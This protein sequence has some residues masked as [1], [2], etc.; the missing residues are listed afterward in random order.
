MKMSIK[1]KLLIPVS[2]VF[3]LSFAVF[4]WFS[5]T[6]FRRALDANLENKALNSVDIVI[7]QVESGRREVHILSD[8]L[9]RNVLRLA[10]AVREIVNS[11]D[12][13]W[14]EENFIYLAGQIGVGEI[15]ITDSEG[16]LRWG[17]VAGFYGFDFGTS[18]QTIPF[19]KA[20]DDPGFELAQ[21]P[22][23]RGADNVLFQYI[24][25]AGFGDA[26]IVQ[27]GLEPRELEQ[28][29]AETDISGKITGFQADE[30]GGFA[31]GVSSD[32]EILYHRNTELPGTSA[33]EEPWFLE[34]ENIGPR[35]FYRYDSPDGEV[36][37]AWQQLGNEYYAVQL[38]V[39]PYMKA[40]T[41]LLLSLVTVVIVAFIITA[42]LVYIF[43]HRL[44][45]RPL[46]ELETVMTEIS[47]GEGDLTWN[48][49]IESEDEVGRV[50]GG[51]NKFIRT[52][53]KLVLEIKQSSDMTVKAKNT[54][55]ST[56]EETAASVAE[57]AA[58]INGIKGQM[59]NL[60]G[61]ITT[62]STAIE[63]VQTVIVEL[64]SQIDEQTAAVEQSSA[65]INQMV[66]SLRNVAGITQ[67]K[68]DATD[69]LVDTT[70]NGGEQMEETARVVSD[71]HSSIDSISGMVEVIEGI[72]SQTNLL[73]MNAAIE[74]AHAGDAGR[75]FAVVADEIRKLAETSAENSKG[76]GSELQGIVRKIEAAAVASKQTNEAFEEIMKE[77]MD[78]S[79]A[80]DEISGS[81]E[82][83][84]EGG[85]QI[86]GAMERLNSVSG[87][88]QEGAIKMT[89]GIEPM[90]EAMQQVRRISTEVL[91]AMNEISSGTG[92]ISNAMEE[93]TSMTHTLDEA[94]S[95]L[96]SEVNRFK[97]E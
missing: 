2:L 8:A 73:S 55:A 32:G 69:R 86:L 81:T 31:F 91:G 21:E 45:A 95:R 67:T 29:L 97:T 65:S 39:A 62:S 90:I 43:L 28:A 5:S 66:A 60:D 54:I 75:G 89:H 76:I 16:V 38:D 6:A 46:K 71:I 44:A 85:S 27:I 82:E 19:L 23:R 20:L 13:E 53:K 42:F 80:L 96:E 30:H 51:L 72:A 58:N 64:H 9:N 78:V 59:T 40:Y 93:L 14:T 11:D 7:N 79:A 1:Y 48:L 84:S 15:H 77:V 56:T 17:N 50:A 35:G 83:L 12:F 24:G 10:R 87:H 52:M 22:Q 74:A 3:I 25:V 34:R 92:E 63:G 41:S 18:D 57:I 61:N 70:R 68:K 94:S 47:S 37:V 26:G 4:F 49:K 88:V 33:A 36:I